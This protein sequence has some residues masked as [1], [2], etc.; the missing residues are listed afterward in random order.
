MESR[1]GADSPVWLDDDRGLRAGAAVADLLPLRVRPG[2]GVLLLGGPV[3]HRADD[4]GLRTEGQQVL[5]LPLV[6]LLLGA[7]LLDAEGLT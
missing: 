7:G 2:E 4:G 5:L 6:N 3:G 1:G